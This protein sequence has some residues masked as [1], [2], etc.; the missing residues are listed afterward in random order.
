MRTRDTTARQ[1]ALA[2]ALALGGTG[3][4]AAATVQFATCNYV[5]TL[6]GTYVLAADLTCPIGD[7]ID[8]RA[9]N[10]QLVLRNHTLAGGNALFG[11]TAQDVT[12]LR[13]M[14]GTITGF[15]AGFHIRDTSGTRLVGVTASGNAGDGIFLLNCMDCLVAGSRASDNG[16]V[17]I[18]L[19]NSGPNTRVV[20]STATGNHFAGIELFGSSSTGDRLAGNLATGNLSTDLFDS[21]LP[22]CVNTWRV[23]TFATDNEA[24][25]AA[26][27]GKGC[28][29]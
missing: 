5:I 13:I 8:V 6:P 15:Q 27:P 3:P 14:G 11:I 17:G 25:A 21:H 9:S 24:G 16:N 1:M 22:A 7:G 20:G 12:G 4:A 19:I 28:I 26:G 29:R 10:V 18:N 2:G 23:N